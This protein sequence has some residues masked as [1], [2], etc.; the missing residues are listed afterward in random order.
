MCFE[1]T[2]LA[3]AVG[4]STIYT[5]NGGLVRSQGGPHMEGKDEKRAAGGEGQLNIC[6]VG[7]QTGKT[8][9]FKR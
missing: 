2:G 3:G 7:L 1:L 6:R 4:V 5:R 8:S 9:G